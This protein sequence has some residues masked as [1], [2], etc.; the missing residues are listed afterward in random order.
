MASRYH[1][2]CFLQFIGATDALKEPNII[3]ELMEMRLPKLPERQY[4]SELVIS[5]DSCIEVFA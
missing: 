4:L 3:T 5:P 1:Y 2:P